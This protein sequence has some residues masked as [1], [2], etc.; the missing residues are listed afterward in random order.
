M[1]LAGK[2]AKQNDELAGSSFLCLHLF[3]G[4]R[5]VSS[6]Y[7]QLASKSAFTRLLF[8]TVISGPMEI[9]KVS[10]CLLLAVIDKA[11]PLKAEGILT[12]YC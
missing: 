5:L 11:W 7:W 9:I 12:A 2:G 1:G 6:R 10:P 4:I 8:V 3:L